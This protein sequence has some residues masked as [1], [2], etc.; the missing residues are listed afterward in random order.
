MRLRHYLVLLFLIPFLTYLSSFGNAFVWDDEQF[1][2]SNQY[3]LTFNI[4]KIFRESTTSG[5]GTNSDYYRPLTTL[6]FAFEANL[7]GLH[8]LPFHLTNTLLHIA[9]GIFI[10]LL[11]LQL[12][13]RRQHSFWLAL[14]FLIHPIQTEAVSYINSRGDSLHAFFGMLSLLSFIAVLKNKTIEFHLYNLKFSFSTLFFTLAAIL[15]YLCAVLSKEIGLAVAGIHSIIFTLFYFRSTAKTLGAFVKEHAKALQVLAG[16]GVVI[17]CYLFLRATAL[18]FN[19]TFNLYDDDSLYSE[20][21]LVR[22]LT[23]TKVVWIYCGLL[24]VPYPLHMERTTELVT[25]I[26]SIWP[27]LT[28]L[29]IT[30]LVT[31]GIKEFR[32]KKTGY[33][34][35]GTAWFFG[36]LVPVSGIIPING[37]LYEHW[38][39]LPMVGFFLVLSRLYQFLSTDKLKIIL[40][41]YLQT[42]LMVVACIYIVLTIRQNYFWSTPVRFYEYLLQYTASARIYNNLAMAYAED[43]NNQKAIQNYLQALEIS[44]QYPQTYHNLANT[45]KTIGDNN[46]AI[47]NYLKVLALQPDF[48]F[49]YT[50]LIELLV[51][52]KRFDETQQV[53]TIIEEEWPDNPAV[54]EYKNILSRAVELDEKSK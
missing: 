40:T 28:V 54:T 33:I 47:E 53:I 19:N 24:L 16:I 10:F 7:W 45:Y 38:L 29:L 41:R 32:I 35:F 39:Y 17:V 36:L 37:V 42:F 18:N 46:L 25:S 49:S 44:N 21:L 1:I 3:V 6:S 50:S 5:A 27:L 11:L 30:G 26:F 48:Y 4:P 15:L 20:S 13:L 12:G 51:V 23:F 14:F 9:T 34:L 52:E 43:G 8:P 22:L 31:L 2:Y